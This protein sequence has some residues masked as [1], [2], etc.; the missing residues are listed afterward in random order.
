[1][2]VEAQPV[3]VIGSPGIWRLLDRKPPPEL[4]AIVFVP[5]LAGDGNLW[6]PWRHQPL[7]VAVLAL[8]D[9]TFD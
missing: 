2:G 1:M 4:R 5:L 8:S 3:A 9:E 6:S 7:Q